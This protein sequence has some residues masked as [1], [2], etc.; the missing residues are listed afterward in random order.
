M[1]DILPFLRE[2]LMV[3][4][5]FVHGVNA[6]TTGYSDLLFSAILREYEKGPRQ[7]MIRDASHAPPKKVS[8]NI[9]N[10]MRGN[11]AIYVK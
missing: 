4:L 9:I 1:Q 8:I 5:I 11:L 6:Q 10:I 3:H 7:D 2:A